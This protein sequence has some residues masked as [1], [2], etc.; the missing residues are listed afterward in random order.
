MSKSWKQA[1][2]AW[3][4]SHKVY[5]PEA[6]RRG[7]EGN[8]AV[9]FTVEPSGQVVAVA[10]VHSSGSPRL[11]AAAEALLRNASLPPFEASMPRTPITT[12]VE[13]RYRLNDD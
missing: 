13:L 7:E 1:L 8:V 5:P 6:R 4:A 12:T 9:R 3:F 10:V 2:V 11:D